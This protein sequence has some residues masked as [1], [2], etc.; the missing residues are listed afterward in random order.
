MAPGR[1]PTSL[2]GAKGGA[3]RKPVRPGEPGGGGRGAGL[4][5]GGRGGGL[6][7]SKSAWESPGGMQN[8]G[9]WGK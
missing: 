6:S 8:P 3:S 7:R 5:A 9:G 4:P 1:G 2:R